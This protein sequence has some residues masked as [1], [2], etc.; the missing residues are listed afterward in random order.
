MNSSGGGSMRE[1]TGTM[2]GRPEAAAE[3]KAFRERE[4]RQ[5]SLVW[6][7]AVLLRERRTITG[8]TVVGVVIA[9]LI[10]V[11]RGPT[12]TTTFSFV[13]AAAQ[14]PA[15][16]GLASLAGQFG[17][18]LGTSSGQSQSPQFYADLLRTRELL[19]PI[20]TDSVPASEASAPR[21]RLSEFLGVTGGTEAVVVD[22]T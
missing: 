15:R 18:S 20:A 2:T 16:A 11:F 22:N 10:A 12:Y 9:L 3:M 6:I 7:L 14:D 8:L 13:P 1:I 5:V 21:M 19:A 4:E 17:L